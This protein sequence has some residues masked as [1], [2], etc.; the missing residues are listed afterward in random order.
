MS[1]IP[2]TIALAIPLAVG[3]CLAVASATIALDS[4]SPPLP[5][6][7]PPPPGEDPRSPRPDIVVLML[8]DIPE[9]DGRLWTRLPIIRRLFVDGGVRFSDAHGETP[10]CCPGRAGFL[11]GLHTHHH[12]A[13][14]TDGSLFEPGETIA[15]ALDKVG[16]HTI[17][18]GKYL[19]LFERVFPKWPPGWDEFHGFG[20]AYYGYT[21]WSDGL[22]RRYGHRPRDY[23]T[24]VIARRA[25]GALGR[26]P[27]DRP[28]F[29]WITPF[30]MHKPWTVAPR[31]RR[32][33]RCRLAPWR[34]PGYMERDV[35]DKPAYVRSYQI[36]QPRGYGLGRICRGLLSVDQL[37]GKVVRELKRMGRLD[38]T[39]LILTSDNGMTYG[40]HRILHDKKSPYASQIPF[41]VRWPRVLGTRPRRVGE[42]IQNID[43]GPTLC[44]IAGC[45]LGPYPTGQARPDGRSFLALLTGKR[46]TLARPAVLTSYL[47]PGHRVTPYWSVTTTSSSPLSRERCAQRRRAGCRWVYTEYASG[48]REL[49]D[50]SNGPCHA[51]RRGMAGDPCMLRNKAGR[52]RY[53]SVEAS[54]RR[55]LARLV[56][57]RAF[58]E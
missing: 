8:D 14:K 24:D 23:S 22:P 46:S 27:A 29:A 13:Y 36:K 20:G 35:R 49:Y 54:L 41:Y 48:E 10:T 33:G 57:R 43:L 15:T 28:L 3:A 50:V 51:W 42:R 38:N 31:H 21:L 26:V 1:R 53:A 12:G 40:S 5:G 11:T 37:L 18:V 16:Y 7:P 44:D 55:E 34:P 4:A 52:G 47:E 30:A 9:L 32:S 56:P 17:Q 39:M 19:N 25:V 2:R 6:D 58:F 45:G